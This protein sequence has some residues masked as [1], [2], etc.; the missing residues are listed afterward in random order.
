MVCA[1][2]KRQHSEINF[3]VCEVNEVY[4]TEISMYVQYVKP[5][6][7]KFKI[8]PEIPILHVINII[9][10]NFQSKISPGVMAAI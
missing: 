1:I 7:L 3:K 5:I 2:G 8:N 9:L 4:C 6:A 10:T